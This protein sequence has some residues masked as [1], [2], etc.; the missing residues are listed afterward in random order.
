MGFEHLD[1][2]PLS[3]GLKHHTLNSI[4]FHKEKSQ[5]CSD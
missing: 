4:L 5:I 2:E 3:V 1:A